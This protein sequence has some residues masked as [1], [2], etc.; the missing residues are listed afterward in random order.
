MKQSLQIAVRIVNK[1]MNKSPL[2]A[3]GVVASDK[4]NWRTRANN[5]PLTVTR[6][7]RSK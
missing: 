5:R 1:M 6:T 4:A 3:H 2:T 7:Q